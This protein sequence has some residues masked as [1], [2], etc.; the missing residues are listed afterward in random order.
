MSVDGVVTLGG[1]RVRFE[2]PAGM[3]NHVE[4]VFEGEYDVGVEFDKPP[5]ILDIGANCGSFAIWAAVRWSTEAITCYEPHP[6]TFRS[7]SKNLLQRSNHV[8]LIEAAVVG[9]GYEAATVDLYPGL[10]NCGESSLFN[11]GEQDM[12]TPFVVRAIRA[13]DLPTAEI[14]KIDTEGAELEILRGYDLRDTVAVM[15]EWHS[16]DDRRAIDAMLTIERGFELIGAHVYSA[17]RGVMK[18]TRA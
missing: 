17:T 2:C 10:H 5:R 9:D 16:A 15:V 14:V 4:R 3:K 8:K 18:F 13:S 1:P 12:A 6:D 11:L 7:L